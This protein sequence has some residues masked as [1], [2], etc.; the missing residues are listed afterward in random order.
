MT[1]A[2][3]DLT[4]PP[5]TQT[6]PC[7]GDRRERGVALVIVLWTLTLLA[8]LAGTFSSASRTHANLAFNVIERAKAE[9][10]A[11]AAVSRAIAGLLAAPEDGGLRVDQ[12]P[13]AWA[14]DSGEVVFAIADEGAKIDLN[15]A[16]AELLAPVFTA[17]GVPP[18]DS[19]RLAAAI[20]D[21]RDD[22]QI[23]SPNGAEAADYRRARLP[24]GPKDAPFERVDELA[25]VLGMTPDLAAR[26]S[27]LFTVHTGTA[28]PVL[29]L[30]PPE[31][32]VLLDGIV[33]EQGGNG[34]SGQ[35]APRAGNPGQ[36]QTAARPGAVRP[37]P[38]G[39]AETN[40]LSSLRAEGSDARSETNIFTIHAE[41]RSQRG[42][43]F[44]REAVVLIEPDAVPPFRLLDIRQGSRRFWV[45]R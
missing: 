20:V 23:V 2:C 43:I 27:P 31:Y 4:G 15:A 42:A 39:A 25:L 30:M 37:R 34:P 11:D 19:A 16:D 41:A 38:A 12:T 8:V 32:Q 22:D 26:V 17:L 40:A 3:G 28:E 10:L 29:E 36:R 21:F 5:A 1:A 35:Q 9:A 45:D 18:R 33:G 44:V 13:Y 6:Q 7:A 24:H 14:F